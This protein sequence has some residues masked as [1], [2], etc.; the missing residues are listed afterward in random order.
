MVRN[1]LHIVILQHNGLHRI[2]DKYSY[3]AWKNLQNMVIFIICLSNS[4]FVLHFSMKA[5]A[6][7]AN[8]VFYHSISF[9][10]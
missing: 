8:L 9:L 7:R 10:T 5:V 6:K 2:G 1:K 4:V 3:V